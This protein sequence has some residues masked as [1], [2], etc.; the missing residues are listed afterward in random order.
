MTEKFIV[1]SQP[2]CP[3]CTL[4]KNYLES[5]GVTPEVRDISTKDEWALNVR[6]MGYMGV[7]VTVKEFSG[8]ERHGV[9]R[10]STIGFN[11]EALDKMIDFII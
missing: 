1:Y 2:N 11:V 5:R 9:Q 3:N 4:V 7:P 6:E 10:T 8:E